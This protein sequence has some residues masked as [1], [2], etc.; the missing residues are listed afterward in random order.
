MAFL[1]SPV[2]LSGTIFFENTSFEDISRDAVFLPAD[3][4]K[5]ITSNV[6]VSIGVNVWPKQVSF[7]MVNSEASAPVIVKV[8]TA[9]FSSPF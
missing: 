4:G 1:F 8:P 6:Q 7:S 3:K 9:R 5:N 2:P